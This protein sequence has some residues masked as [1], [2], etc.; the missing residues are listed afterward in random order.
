MTA[1]P[2]PRAAWR[3]GGIIDRLATAVSLVG[4]DD[5]GFGDAR[6][7]VQ[8]TLDL[9]GIDVLAAGDDHVLL[10][11]VDGEVAVGIA[12]ADVLASRRTLLLVSLMAGLPLAASSTIAQASP[13]NP[14]ETV[15]TPHDAIKFVAWTNAPPNSGAANC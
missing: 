14:T 12:G 3:R 15:I 2:G 8:H 7:L 10:A 1:R 5:G 13:L 11:V 4:A 6:V 9:G